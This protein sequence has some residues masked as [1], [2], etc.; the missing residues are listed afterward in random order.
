MRGAMRLTTDAAGVSQAAEYDFYENIRR[1]VTAAPCGVEVFSRCRSHYFICRLSRR[2]QQ[3]D[4]L[5]NLHQHVTIV[6]QI[7]ASGKCPVARNDF[8]LLVSLRQKSV[9][10]LNHAVASARSK[11]GSARE[12]F[13]CAQKILS[14]LVARWLR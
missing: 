11:A 12:I 3:L 5:P 6:L 1:H 13:C 8:C 9:E 2:N 7:S 14:L 4:A 10:G